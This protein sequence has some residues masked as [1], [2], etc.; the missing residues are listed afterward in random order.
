[1][2]SRFYHK[3]F[4][5]LNTDELYDMMALRQEIFIV[6]QDCPYLDADGVDLKCQHVLAYDS[7]GNLVAYARIVPSGLSYQDYASIGR[8]V[9]KHTARGTGLGKKLMQYSI[10]ICHQLHPE[11][12]IK[13]SAQVYALGFYSNLG[14]EKIGNEYLEDDIPHHAMVL[15]V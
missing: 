6:E 4:S 8:V 5:A 2:D 9:T 14:F 11:D 7:E 13:I 15:T 1:M 10:N 12:T 3:P